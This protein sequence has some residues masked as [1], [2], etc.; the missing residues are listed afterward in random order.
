[1][2][3]SSKKKWVFDS[4][5]IVQEKQSVCAK[6]PAIARAN[7]GFEPETDRTDKIEKVLNI[8]KTTYDFSD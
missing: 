8:G 1:M 3:N 6:H 4:S 5:Y 7:L 2:V